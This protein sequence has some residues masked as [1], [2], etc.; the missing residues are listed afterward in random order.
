MT[1]CRNCG[2][3]VFTCGC[4]P[5]KTISDADWTLIHD[6]VRKVI[7]TTLSRAEY[8]KLND[9]LTRVASSKPMEA[10]GAWHTGIVSL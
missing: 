5:M 6:A 4:K 9:V 2:T 10:P 8:K 3:N 7:D 1:P